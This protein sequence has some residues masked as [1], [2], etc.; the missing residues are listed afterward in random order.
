[1]SWMLDV[2]QG[3][4]AVGA[5]LFGYVKLTSHQ[6]RQVKAISFKM[7][8]L[9]GSAI[10]TAASIR[11]IIGFGISEQPISRRDVLWLLLNIWNGFAYGI[12]ALGIIIYWVRGGQDGDDE[13]KSTDG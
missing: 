8:G 13:N 3:V 11:E 10:I 6:R 5:L 7:L 4:A 12:C 9:L 1:M 2:V